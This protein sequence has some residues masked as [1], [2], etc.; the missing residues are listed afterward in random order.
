MIK[1]IPKRALILI[2][3]F[4]LVLLSIYLIRLYSLTY[5]PNIN[6]VHVINLD[7]D[8]KR[9]D[10]ILSSTKS[11]KVPVERWSAVYGKS[12][13]QQEMKQQGVG[14]VMTRPGK[15]SSHEQDNNLRNQG[16]VGCF[17]SHRNLLTYLAS[18]DVP[19]NY[20]HL[21]LEDDVNL[22]A[23][24]SHSDDEWHTIK[25]KIPFDW[26]IVYLDITTPTGN[27]ISKRIM[28][29]TYKTEDTRGNW[30]THAYLVRHGSI[31]TKIL[32][33]LKYM[34][35]AYDEQMMMKFNEWNCYTVVP[36]IIP[37]NKELSCDSNIQNVD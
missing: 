17:L 20:G 24:F 23:D 30:G 36:G 33:W 1:H 14:Y 26:D 28:K 27:L 9:W 5:R 15:G 21:I 29:L 19:E 12:L 34:I 37:L 25:Q 32:P 31:K 22:P 13:T 7:K 18:L 8:T 4:I 11:V 3:I 6:T 35:D 2:G 10:N 16:V